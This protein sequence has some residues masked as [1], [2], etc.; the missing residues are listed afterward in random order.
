MAILVLGWKLKSRE[1]IFFLVLEGINL[2]CFCFVLFWDSR[3][4]CV[5][6]LYE[7]LSL[8]GWL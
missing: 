6:E 5:S 4:L 8:W 2:E 7:V 3:G 1:E